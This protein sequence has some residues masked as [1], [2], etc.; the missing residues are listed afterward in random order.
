MIVVHSSYAH[1]F[2]RHWKLEESRTESNILLFITKGSLYYWINKE[3]VHLRKGEALFIPQG[4]M[5][6]AASDQQT[7]HQR[8]ST[9]FSL[10]VNSEDDPWKH[11]GVP[12]E[13]ID[14]VKDFSEFVGYTIRYLNEQTV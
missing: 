4:S 13:P 5:R 9:H 2:D 14:F 12:H 7:D 3:E 1:E 6:S 8:Y 10:Q 11:S